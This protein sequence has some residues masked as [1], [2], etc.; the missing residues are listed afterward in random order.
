VCQDDSCKR[1][2]HTPDTSVL[3]VYLQI[4]GVPAVTGRAHKETA[5]AQIVPV[6]LV[7]GNAINSQISVL[8]SYYFGMSQHWQLTPFRAESSVRSRVTV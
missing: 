5:A 2:E 6:A 4:G 8:L 1:C 3:L 7:I